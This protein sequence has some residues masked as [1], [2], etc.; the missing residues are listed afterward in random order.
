MFHGNEIQHNFKNS[1]SI[2]RR[3]DKL[4]N[5]QNPDPINSNQNQTRKWTKTI[6]TPHTNKSHLVWE[7]EI[8]WLT[9]LEPFS[10]E[11]AA[12][13]LQLRLGHSGRSILFIKQFSQ[14]KNKLNTVTWLTPRCTKILTF[15]FW[16]HYKGKTFGGIYSSHIF[17]KREN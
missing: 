11:R 5:Q 4:K 16:N 2:R 6:I 9:E 1:N 7:L 13:W 10:F 12:R 3:Q 14:Y 8:K 17:E 15:D